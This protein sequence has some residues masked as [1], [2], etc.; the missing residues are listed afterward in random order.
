MKLRLLSLFLAIGLG[1]GFVLCADEPSPLSPTADVAS[2]KTLTEADVIAL[3]TAALQKDFVKDRGELELAFTQPWTAPAIPDEPLTVKVSGLPTA[4]VTSSFILR[5]QLCT[6]TRT[7]GTWQMAM[8]AHVWRDAWV[9]R[10]GLTRGASIADADIARERRDV[11][12]VRETLAEFAPGDP[13]L[14]LAASVSAGNLLLARDLKPRAVLHRGQTA[15]A[16]LSDGGLD[17]RLKVEVLEDGAPGQ[18]IHARN[19]TSQ[20]NLTGKVVDEQT[21]LVSL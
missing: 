13:S 12:N 3:L 7:V 4:G 17:I 20:R 1:G 8:Q 11:L 14:E 9:A 21:I 10:S 5:F 15:N 19:A 2:T 6:A 16:I 18:M